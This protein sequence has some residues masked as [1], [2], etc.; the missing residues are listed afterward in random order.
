ML[1]A[2]EQGLKREDIYI[3]TKF[4]PIEGQDINNIPY[5]KDS[6]ISEQIMQSFEVS[7]KT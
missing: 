2:Y 7:K 6:S 4:I 5:E 1:K 3:Q